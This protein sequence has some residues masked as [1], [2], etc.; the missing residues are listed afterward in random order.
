[1]IKHYHR[2]LSK[3]WS[4]SLFY[5]MV[6]LWFYAFGNTIFNS[7]WQRPNKSQ[8]TLFSED[9]CG[10]LQ[11][12]FISLLGNLIFLFDYIFSIR[13]HETITYISY[14][15]TKERDSRGHLQHFYLCC[16][17]FEVFTMFHHMKVH[18]FNSTLTVMFWNE[19]TRS[20]QKHNRNRRNHRLNA[21]W[22]LQLCPILALQQWL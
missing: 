6:F 12:I 21:S 14:W 19:K 5:W 16:Q 20:I 17:D 1:M 4:D 18:T 11:V 22:A 15:S 2:V 8:C 9:N 3:L 13:N 10:S 7:T